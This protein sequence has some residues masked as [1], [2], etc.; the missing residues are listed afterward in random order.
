[1]NTKTDQETNLGVSEE[2]LSIE[3]TTKC[4][5]ACLHCFARAGISKP[6]SLSLNITREIISEGY[7]IG[8]RQLHITGGEPLLWEGLFE[9]LDY[10]FLIGYKSVFL[11]TNATLLTKDISKRLSAYDC[12]SISISLEGTKALHDHLRGGGSYRKA[13]KGIENGLKAGI[14]PIIFTTVRKSLL[15][16]LPHFAGD[17]YNKYS[18]I[19]H[20]TLIQLIRNTNDV[21]AL[22]EELLDPEDILKL[23]R[24]VSLL[25]LFGF[26]TIV[27]NNPLVN[28]VSKLIEMPWIPRV[29]PLYRDGSI[30]VRANRDVCLS[31][32]CRDS[33]GKYESGKIE[34]VLASDWYRKAVA[35]DER[36]CPSC[37]F[38]ELCMEEGMVRPSERYWEINQDALFCKRVLN[39]I[40]Q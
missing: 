12:L 1:M 24:I 34:K 26:R 36:T 3:V 16:E 30:F 8:Y 31:H 5:G 37:K 23:V 4:N 13:T 7:N 28:V 39:S 17:L 40:V 38:S 33:F 15:T 2:S 29:H 22:S 10:A 20:L 14:N 9:V 25:N 32:S 27:K 11:N 21:F 35:Q 19:K 18:S 6:S